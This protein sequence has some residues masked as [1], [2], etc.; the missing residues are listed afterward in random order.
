MI[1]REEGERLFLNALRRLFARFFSGPIIRPLGLAGPIFV[2]LIALPLLRPLRHPSESEISSD[3][4]LRLATVRA[5]VEHHSLA[6]DSHRFA[7]TPGTVQSTGGTFST[8]PP[9]MSLLLVAPAWAIQK[10]GLSFDANPSLV[11]YLLTLVGTTLPVAAA[12]GLIYRMGRLFELQR[13]WRAG[14]GVVAVGASGLLSY[15]TV[16]NSHAP[17]AVLVLCDA[18]CLIHV[19]AMQ[20]AERRAGWFALAGACGALAATIEPTA[21]LLLI[22]LGV[23][24]A[25]MSFSVGRRVVGLL[26][27]VIGCVPVLAV[28]AAW[29]LPITGDVLPAS[30]H[31]ATAK[32]VTKP[33]DLDVDDDPP[34]NFFDHVSDALKSG[35]STLFGS[36]GPLSHFPILVLGAFGIGAV[37]HRHWPTSTKVLASATA[38]S[39]VVILICLWLGW[40]RFSE[41]AFASPPSLIFSPL[42]LFWAGAW[43]RREHRA[44]SYTLA[45]ALLVYSMLVG[46]VGAN[47]PMPKQGYD[48]FSAAQA[49]RKV[50]QLSS[51]R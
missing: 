32:H 39:A 25:A 30:I 47:D 33:V 23:S 17:A 10:F 20:R 14:L 41:A 43:L 3:E 40:P 5:L 49:L 46:V 11:Q 21:F 51:A 8:Q 36:H 29:N 37:M 19:A 2:L 9:M 15:A 28:H 34:D 6:L 27:Y 45:G 48:R 44:V 12:A 35:F 16:L 7:R 31:F 24:I 26:V 38:A 50:V 18:A 13:P 1:T 4:Q 42:L 22:L